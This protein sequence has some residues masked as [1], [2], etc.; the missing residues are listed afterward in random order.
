MRLTR[1]GRFLVECVL[2]W[3]CSTVITVAMLAI[4]LG[5]PLP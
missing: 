5:S 2:I 1:R 3:A 4:Y